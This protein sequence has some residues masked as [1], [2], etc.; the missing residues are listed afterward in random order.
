[1]EQS[2]L[3]VCLVK[4]YFS[5]ETSGLYSLEVII[6]RWWG[7][8]ISRKAIWSRRCKKYDISNHVIGMKF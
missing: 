7:C 8:K 5:P 1:M 4:D 3:A 2:N 6:W